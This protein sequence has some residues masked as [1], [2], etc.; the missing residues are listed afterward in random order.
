MNISTSIL[1]VKSLCFPAPR[2]LQSV[3]ALQT[4]S[5]SCLLCPCAL[6]TCIINCLNNF[7]LLSLFA[8]F[9]CTHFITSASAWWN[10]QT[11][12]FCLFINLYIFLKYNSNM[13]SCKKCSHLLRYSLKNVYSRLYCNKFNLSIKGFTLS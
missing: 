2:K 11:W 1:I 12:N 3:H 6:P 8:F 13:H 5:S 10:Y 9:D 4:F 7:S